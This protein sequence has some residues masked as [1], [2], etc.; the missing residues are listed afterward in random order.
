MTNT[1]STR[2]ELRSWLETVRAD[3]VSEQA[4]TLSRALR[5]HSYLAADAARE[6]LD[7]SEW[8]LI[9]DQ[10]SALRGQ[11][12][13]ALVLGWGDVIV[14]RS[15]ALRAAVEARVTLPADE[16]AAYLAVLDRD[17]A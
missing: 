2:T 14:E 3:L 13:R 4:A 1:K 17:A 7:S 15:G 9:V 6:H 8:A 16:K 11:Q 5:E 12:Y 10:A